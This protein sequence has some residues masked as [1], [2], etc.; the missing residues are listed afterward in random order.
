MKE[1]LIDQKVTTFNYVLI[2][3][4]KNFSTLVF[5]PPVE[6]QG[7]NI[8]A[9][10]WEIKAVNTK[11]DSFYIT[12][13]SGTIHEDRL[14]IPWNVDENFTGQD[15]GLC[16]TLIGRQNDEIRAKFQVEGINVKKE[17]EAA[18][19]MQPNYFE[20]VIEKIQEDAQR[21]ETAA[22]EAESYSSHPPQI[23]ESGNWG[24]WDGTAYK[25]TGKP[26]RGENGQD[27]QDGRVYEVHAGTGVNVDNSDPANPVV[28]ATVSGAVESVVAGANI[29]VNDSDPAHPVI[30]ALSG[31]VWQDMEPAE[32][33]TAAYAKF[34]RL[35]DSLALAVIDI[36]ISSGTFGNLQKLCSFPAGVNA[37]PITYQPCMYWQGANGT[38]GLVFPG[39]AQP[40]GSF[41]IHTNYGFEN[42]NRVI[43][44]LILELLQGETT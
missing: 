6:F 7:V 4:E 35:T 36:S 3:G 20:S 43:A 28:S 44:T 42:K 22:N 16:V 21:A 38:I 8:S 10:N 33:M 17:C 24:A 1:I 13:L 39:K 23:L 29:Q 34:I 40:S 31:A 37:L 12:P 18:E 41:G 15:G 5:M 9:L 32:G 19:E 11:T 14:K 30:S 26:S 25:D 27:G 2:Q